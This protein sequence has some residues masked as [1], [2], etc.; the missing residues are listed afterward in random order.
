[1]NR[2]EELR[3]LIESNKETIKSFKQKIED[4]KK[5]IRTWEYRISNYENE[6]YSGLSKEE[7]WKGSEKE[8]K[9]IESSCKNS[10]ANKK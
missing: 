1:M 2:K 9:Q 3:E 7:Y 5:Y 8:L 10:K 6:Y 4:Y